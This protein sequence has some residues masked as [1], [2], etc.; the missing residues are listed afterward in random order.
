MGA[1]DASSGWAGDRHH[2]RRPLGYDIARS[3]VVPDS[4]HFATNTAVIA[5]IA[6]IAVAAP[7]AATTSA[8]RVTRCPQVRVGV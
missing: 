8:S 1:R 3:T 5:V 7:F 2:D 4:I 6:A